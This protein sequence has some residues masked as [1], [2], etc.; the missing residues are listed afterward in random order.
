MV[1]WEEPKKRTRI[2]KV[3][4]EAIKARYRNKCCVCGKTERSAGVLEKAHVK[5]NS[6]GGTQYFPLC[7]T[8]HKKYDKGLLTVAELKKLGLTKEDY[9]RLRPKKPKKK[10]EIDRLLGG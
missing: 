1:F 8:C 4:W 3:E 10:D 6:R 2:G 5:A 9:A 7:P